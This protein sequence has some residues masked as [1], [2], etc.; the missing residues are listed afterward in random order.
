MN[1]YQILG[2][3]ENASQDDIKK[4]YKKLAMKHHPD[5]GGDNKKFQEISQAYDTIGDD[6]KRAR[7]NS[8]L[9]GMNNP[10]S[11]HSGHPGFANFGD[12]FG[13]QFGQ[14]FASH[15]V[16][17][18]RDLN[19]R[20]AVSFKQSYLGTQTEARYTMP[21]GKSRTIVIDV[22]AGVQSGQVL[23]YGGLGDD[24]IPNVPP[25]NLNVTVLVETD[26]IW[27]RR[28]NDVIRVV[29]ITV[30]E[31]MTGCTKQVNCLDGS[32]MP[33]KLKPGTQHGAEYASGG[34]GF[35]DI[36]TGRA[37]SLIILVNVLIPSI[38]NSD[39][40]KKLEDIYVEIN[41]SS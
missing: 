31:A 32:I 6:N 8:E 9:N 21:S 20:I 33:L 36:N 13:F 14:G 28:G 35:K 25:G 39:L 40:I 10:F 7:Y 4:A 1:Y 24:N 38:T 37:G 5:R 11:N 23:R 16:K 34:R 18:N 30:L 29:E 2:V 26:P 27:E 15:Q 17:R 22:P 3:D 19:L 12:I 41:H